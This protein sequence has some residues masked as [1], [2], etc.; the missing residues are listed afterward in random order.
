MEGFIE[1]KGAFWSIQGHVLMVRS[2]DLL[3]L[4]GIAAGYAFPHA[5]AEEG[6]MIQFAHPMNVKEREAHAWLYHR[7]EALK[8]KEVDEDPEPPYTPGPLVA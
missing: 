3:S 8:P 4:Y 6:D 5:Y 7:M 2:C 1:H